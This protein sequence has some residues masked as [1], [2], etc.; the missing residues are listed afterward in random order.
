[1]P[2]K[3]YM[4]E[5]LVPSRWCCFGRFWNLWKVG[6][7][8]RKLSTEGKPWGFTLCFLT[9]DTM[10]WASSHSSYH[11]L[12]TMM[13]WIPSNG[14]LLQIFPFLNWFFWNRIF[15]YS[16]GSPRTHSANQ[17][18]FKMGDQLPSVSWVLGLKVW[19]TTAQLTQN[20]LLDVISCSSNLEG[21]NQCLQVVLWLSHVCCGSHI[22]AHTH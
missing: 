21:V 7:Y 2:S 13:G 1:M 8:G 4:S 15:L 11:A 9:V 12:P 20:L 18:G 3:D 10:S 6:P 22:H 19:A 17:A 5:H 16:P 14:D